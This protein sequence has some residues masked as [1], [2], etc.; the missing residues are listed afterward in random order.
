MVPV[1]LTGFHPLQRP[2]LDEAATDPLFT[3]IIDEKRTVVQGPPA[4][5][6]LVNDRSCNLYCPSCRTERIN[7]Q[8]GPVS[9]EISRIQD[10]LL[11][12]YLSEPNEQHF[13]LS[14]YRVR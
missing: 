1:S 10:R 8:D 9:R 2:A 5:V 11:E 4:F 6:N 7:H 12:P 14:N 13:V 3:R